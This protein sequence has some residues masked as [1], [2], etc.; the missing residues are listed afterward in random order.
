ML[1]TDTASLLKEE[2]QRT[3]WQML[4]ILFAHIPVVG[5]LIPLGHDSFGFATVAA[6]LVGGIS[7]GT[8][9]LCRG[10]RVCSVIF[11]T[12][13]MLF[14][15]IMIQ[16]QL[17]RIEMHFHIF[18]ALAL[19][20][21][22]RDWLPVVVGAGVIA[23]HHLVLTG[24]QL[25]QVT[26]GQMPL[27]IFNYD[28]SWSIAFLHAAFVVFEAGILVF[29]AIRMA[30]E[31]RESRNIVGIVRAFGARKDLTG[32]LDNVEKSLTAASF[33]E[34]MDQF[35]SLIGK[36]G[37]LSGQLRDS[38]DALMDVSNH[39]NR[40]VGEQQQQTDQ[41]AT[42]T[43]QMAAT[44]QEVAQN[45]QVASESAA[46]ASE[47]SSEG[48]RHVERVEQLTEATNTVLS[49]SSRM[50]NELV[51]K[52]KSI[53]TVIASI[54]D[55]SDQT[56]LLALNAAIEAA[57]AGE[58]G[59]GFAVVADEVRSLS[60][61]TQEFTSDIGATIGDLANVSEAALAAIE[62][63]QTRSRET[64]DA[65]HQAGDA[66]N[67]IRRAIGEVSSMNDQIAS[68]SEQQAATSSQINDSIQKM[69]TQ[70]SDVVT[71][72]GKA[73]QMAEDLE[74]IVGEVDAVIREYR[75]GP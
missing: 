11:A 34:L 47:A 46:R 37:T 25:S 29:F 22:Y 72:A 42:A 16:A 74:R 45:A 8:Y 10:E 70:N 15:A 49:D 19:V 6:L 56:N 4:M 73:R 66:I 1:Q 3:D 38:A 50:V 2:R 18:A 33:N 55:I 65:V 75:T 53:D 39:T 21:M 20:I 51:E 63:G 64:T 54:N 71:E 52:V 59:R 41:A 7:G 69:V 40:I 31:R 36:V 68:A 62:M 9:L 67:A 28:V 14:S 35:S 5:L 26:V 61:R 32:R 57:R 30:S 58:H 13:L 24:L 43:N 60:R 27:V 23:V 12:C 44:I 17:G 48:G